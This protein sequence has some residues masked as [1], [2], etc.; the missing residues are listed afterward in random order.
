MCIL[1]AFLSNYVQNII[2][3]VSINMIVVIGLSVLTG[4]TR[5]FS[6]GQAG[7]M[8]IGAY[9]SAI[10]TTRLH[11]PFIVAIIAGAIVAGVIAYLLGSLTLKLKGDY[12]LI[13]TLGFGICVKVL[14]EYVKITGGAK[15]FSGIP[16]HT[17]LPIAVG[18][19]VAAFV[20]AWTL[21]HSKYGRN[22]TA[23]REQEMAAEAV[24]VQTIKNKKLAFVFSAVLAGWAG[25]LY[26]HNLTF[27]AP[28]IFDL[29]RSS[30]YIITVIIGGMGSLTG[31][32]LG[33]AVITLVP[34]LFRSLSNY[35]M[36]FYGLTVVVIIMVR[37]SG[38]LGY[39]EFSLKKSIAGI[40]RIPQRLK[41]KRRGDLE[42]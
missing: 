29:P 35:R 26:A 5:L 24:G 1:D 11:F 25:A 15:G 2:I 12:F 14:F 42:V 8:S 23:I 18:S 41:S 19:A 22:F 38:I 13:V 31:S 16:Q 21:V 7:F 32:V 10:L 33:S 6:F 3:V 28:K 30:E 37:P 36:L 17:T 9:A 20:L 27:L 40:K 39:K 4:F 34:E